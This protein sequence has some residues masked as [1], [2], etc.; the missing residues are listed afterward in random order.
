MRRTALA[1]A[2]GLVLP[3]AGR[4]QTADTAAPPAASAPAA[5][6][7]K[8][9]QE[10]TALPRHQ[11]KEPLDAFL[12]ANPNS[13]DGNFQ[14]GIWYYEEGRMPEALASFKKVLSLDPSHFRALANASLVLASLQKNEESLTLFETYIAKNPKEARAVAFYGE[15]LWSM[16][17][18]AEGV[19]Q[20]RKAIAIDP[21]CAEAHFNMAVAY[22]ES[23]I[24]REAIR[25]WREVVTLGSPD[26][27]VRQ[28]K[29]NIARAEQKL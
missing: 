26:H 15:T 8:T 21:K 10:I 2:L 14:M 16:G 3:A 24:F 5:A 11:Q 28:A 17:R 29:E 22:A 18:K 13:V 25:E 27:L 9:I 19:E 23:G 4:A 7:A 12:K 20:Y 1:V 6:G